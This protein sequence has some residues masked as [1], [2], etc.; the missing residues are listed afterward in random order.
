MVSHRAMEPPFRHSTAPQRPSRLTVAT[1]GAGTT[2]RSF[3]LKGV[4]F[5][6]HIPT[7]ITGLPRVPK[8]ITTQ[9]RHNLLLMRRRGPPPNTPR[10]PT[11]EATEAG[12]FVAVSSPLVGA[13]E[14]ALKVHNGIPKATMVVASPTQ[15]RVQIP[16]MPLHIGLP[17]TIRRLQWRR[18]M[19]QR[20]TVTTP[21]GPPKTYKWR[22]PARKGSQKKTRHQLSAE[23]P[24]PG[25]NPRH[26][27]SLV[28]A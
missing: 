19:P 11:A 22:I 14:A 16:P 23:R 1:G 4:N 13:S 7:T 21:L 15:P 2:N 8:D 28:L 17:S 10:G 18:A 12:R 9:A 3:P 26:L 6:Q 24:P 20:Q 5:H 25:R 27:I